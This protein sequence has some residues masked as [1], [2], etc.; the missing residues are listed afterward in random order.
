MICFAE[1]T[2][3]HEFAALG[4][5]HLCNEFSSKVL[6][7]EQDGVEALVRCLSSADPDVQKNSI[8]TLALMMQVV[9]TAR[10]SSRNF[11]L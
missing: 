2:V 5:S 9:Y 3:V 11:E 8:E 1:D 6:V 10:N 7:Y 4:L